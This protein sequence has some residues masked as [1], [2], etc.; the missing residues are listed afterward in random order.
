MNNTLNSE[1]VTIPVEE[2]MPVKR[3]THLNAANVGKL[4][5]SEMARSAQIWF[6]S[7]GLNRLMDGAQ[8]TLGDCLVRIFQIPA[9]L[10]SHLLLGPGRNETGQAHA[11]ALAFRRMRSSAVA[12]K[13]T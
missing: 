10:Q 6:S 9:L 13:G 8:K 3:R 1:C 11:W 4:R 5:C 12:S 7:H 2:Q